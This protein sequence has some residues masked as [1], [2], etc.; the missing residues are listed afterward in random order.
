MNRG[1]LLCLDTFTTPAAN[2]PP[3]MKPFTVFLFEQIL[4]FSEIVGKKTQFTSPVYVYKA[5][6]LVRA[7]SCLA[8]LVKGSVCSARNNTHSCF[9][10][11]FVRRTNRESGAMSSGVGGK[12][13]K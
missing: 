7:N 9:P 2:G 3:K 6:F 5:H 11:R 10:P 12:E 1:P 4:I 13:G 8:W